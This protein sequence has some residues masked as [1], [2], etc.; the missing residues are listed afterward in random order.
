MLV[1]VA[2]LQADASIAQDLTPNQ[3]TAISAI[4]QLG[5]KVTVID[6]DGDV[7]TEV[8]LSDHRTNDVAKAVSLLHT[9][10]KCRELVT[11]WATITNDELAV[12]GRLDDL[13][14]LKLSDSF[15]CRNSK[16]SDEG[17]RHLSNL[18]QLRILY[19]ARTRITDDGL[20]HIRALRNLSLIH[21]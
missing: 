4:E 12:I 2:W 10:P 6:S 8:F 7:S 15:T 3:R 9:L 14:T 20:R 13:Q 1:L 5:A 18:K 17:I 21:I 11:Y 19:L 16:I